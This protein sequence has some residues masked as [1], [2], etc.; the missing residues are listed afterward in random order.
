MTLTPTEQIN[1]YAS[2]NSGYRPPI[3]DEMYFS[4]SYPGFNPSVV[5]PNPDIK[6]ERSV[7]LE[8]GMNG[9]FKGL[10]TDTDRLTFKASAFHDKVKDLIT[11]D[12]VGFDPATW[13]MYF[14]TYNI[15]NAVRKGFELSADYLVGNAEFHAGYGMTHAIDKST[16][17]RIGGITPQSFNFRAAYTYPAWNLKAWYRFRWNDGGTSNEETSWGSGEYKRY[18]SFSTHSVGLTWTPTIAGWADFR[19]NLAVDNIGNEKYQRLNGAYGYGRTVRAS[20]SAR[21]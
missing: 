13:T 19:A 18:S 2:A 20:I 17:R 5:L 8:I 4:M 16:H 3:L 6:P 10:F 1:F 14:Q 9:N 21:F 12:M 11:A 7:N 15:G